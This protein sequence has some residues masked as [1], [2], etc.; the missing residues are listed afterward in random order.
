MGAINLNSILETHLEII[1]TKG[2]DVLHG[3]KST[4][5]GYEG[6]GE[7]YFSRIESGQIKAWKKHNSM[8]M[9]I[10]VPLGDVRFVFFLKSPDGA[11]NFLV[12][13]I[14]VSNYIRLTVPP[15]IWFGFKGISQ[16]SS[17]V[18]NVASI[19]HNPNEVNRKNID[20]IK[21]NWS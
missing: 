19:P 20:D 3:L 8:T 17:L 2:G 12:K 6:F 16:S 14:G 1:K 18:L 9:N 4:D 11:A 21:F 13:D 7:A 15:G 10:L 5:L